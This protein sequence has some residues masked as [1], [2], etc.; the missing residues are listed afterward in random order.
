MYYQRECVLYLEGQGVDI[1]GLE[2]G[3]EGWVQGVALI[4]GYR[5]TQCYHPEVFTDPH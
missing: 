4:T 1:P 3:P 5:Q 2:A